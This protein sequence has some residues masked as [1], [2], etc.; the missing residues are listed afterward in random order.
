M[1]GEELAKYI[2]N[3]PSKTLLEIGRVFWTIVKSFEVAPS[4]SLMGEYTLFIHLL[5]LY[6]ATSNDLTIVENIIV[7][8]KGSK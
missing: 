2:K 5:I 1:C 6:G 4:C 8:V 3:N 7:F